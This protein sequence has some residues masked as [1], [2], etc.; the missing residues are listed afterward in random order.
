[1]LCSRTRWAKRTTIQHP[2][3]P[4]VEKPANV[5]EDPQVGRKEVIATPN[6]CL[7]RMR[8][9]QTVLL[10]SMMP[11]SLTKAKVSSS[12]DGSFLRQ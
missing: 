8:S 1:M 7:P 12:P 9:D 2:P 5:V 3:P 6:I 11:K 10:T 4:E